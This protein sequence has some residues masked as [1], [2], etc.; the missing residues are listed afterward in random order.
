ME[1]KPDILEMYASC[2]TVEAKKHEIG[3]GYVWEC[4]RIHCWRNADLG[5]DEVLE[6]AGIDSVIM[7]VARNGK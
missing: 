5:C 2:S 6:R 4:I 1:T 3:L 7:M